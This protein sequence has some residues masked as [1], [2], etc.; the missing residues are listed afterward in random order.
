M[1]KNHVLWPILGTYPI[2][3]SSLI[4]NG[5]AVGRNY[6]TDQTTFSARQ[7]PCDILTHCHTNQLLQ[8]LVI[9]KNDT[10]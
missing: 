4:V 2:T 9:K 5:Q 8:K 6:E 3:L 10:K 1:T 7:P